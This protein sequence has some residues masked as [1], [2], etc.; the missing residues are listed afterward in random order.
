M[1][2]RE[3]AAAFI[4]VAAGAAAS[5]ARAE[6]WSKFYD[7]VRQ[8][9]QAVEQAEPSLFD[10]ARLIVD[11]LCVDE[12]TDLANQMFHEPTRQDIVKDQGVGGAFESFRY[13]MRREVTADLFKVRRDR[14]G[15]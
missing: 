10:G 11:V 12:S 1:L 5:G 7:C 6:D 2:K 14:L 8:Y 3:M 4:V 9:R 13:V 15:L